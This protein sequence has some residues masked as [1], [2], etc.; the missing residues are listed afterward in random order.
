VIEKN[1]MPAFAI[2][3]AIGLSMFLVL[4]FFVVS[5]VLRFLGNGVNDTERDGSRRSSS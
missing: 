2:L 5:L 3:A 4:S 1:T